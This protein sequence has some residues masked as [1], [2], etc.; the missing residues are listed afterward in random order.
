MVIWSNHTQTMC[1]GPAVVNNL[2]WGKA[3][4]KAWLRARGIA[5]VS[6]EDF[7]EG[8]RDLNCVTVAGTKLE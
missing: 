3:W 1:S 2:V 7:S 5:A 8:L 6:A 4:R